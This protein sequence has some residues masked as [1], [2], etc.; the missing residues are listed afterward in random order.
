MFFSH[1]RLPA[2]EL[3]FSPSAVGLIFPLCRKRRRLFKR[4][5]RRGLKAFSGAE[6]VERVRWR[7][8]NPYLLLALL[9]LRVLGYGNRLI[10]L[11]LK[12]PWNDRLGIASLKQISWTMQQLIWVYGW[13]Q[14]R[15]TTAL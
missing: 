3:V 10:L 13:G 8:H 9:E 6:L 14:V 1:P 7:I 15:F 4:Y 11:K 12:F 2:S 5:K